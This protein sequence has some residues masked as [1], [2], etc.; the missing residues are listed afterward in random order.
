VKGNE[1]LDFFD[2][3]EGAHG[4]K[5]TVLERSKGHYFDQK[6][7]RPEAIYIATPAVTVWDSVD[8]AS[9]LGDNSGIP[10]AL[11]EY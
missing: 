7:K 5:P 8:N 6:S 3:Q 9:V 1:K 4:Y 10:A 2:H 11:I